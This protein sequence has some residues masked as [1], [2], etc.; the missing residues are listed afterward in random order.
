[1]ILL[2]APSQDSDKQPLLEDQGQAKNP[3]DKAGQL[4][5]KE[6]LEEAAKKSKA[7]KQEEFKGR[8]WL[9]DLRESD[10]KDSES[11]GFIKVDSSRVVPKASIPLLSLLSWK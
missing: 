3:N 5:M 7:K 8:W 11:G 1:V 9:C 2:L 6:K 4:K 10:L